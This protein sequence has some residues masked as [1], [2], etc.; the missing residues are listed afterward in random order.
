MFS[1]DR[2]VKEILQHF[3]DPLATMEAN[4]L[5]REYKQNQEDKK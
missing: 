5:L 2:I 4:E 3:S 1:A